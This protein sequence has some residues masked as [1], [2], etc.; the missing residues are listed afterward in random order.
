MYGDVT[1]QENITIGEGESLTLDDGASLDAG[2]HNV[3]VD[4]GT[5][6]ENLENSLGDSVKYTPT[7]TT[8]SLPDG[9][10]G[11]EYSTTLAAEGTAPIT[12][13]V[14]NGT[15]P[16]GLSL[17]ESTGEISGT[18]AAAGKYTFEIEAKNDYGS[19]TGELT[20]EIKAAPIYSVSVTPDK[21]NLPSVTEGYNSQ[22]PETITIENAG[23]QTIL[24]EPLDFYPGVT[25]TLNKR[26]LDPGEKAIVT[27]KLK[28]NLSADTPSTLKAFI[29]YTSKD[30]T[31][32]RGEAEF[33]VSYAVKHD[34]T[35]V[36]AK[37]PTHLEDGNIECWYCEYCNLYYT[38]AA[39]NTELNLDKV[40]I[41][42]LKEHTADG[43]GWHSDETNHWNTCACGEK[44]N[45][46]AHTFEWV[47]DKEATAAEAG[48][49]HEECTVCGYAKAAVEIPATGASESS[50]TGDDSSIALWTALLLLAAVVATGTVIYGRKRRE[51]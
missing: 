46:A 42:K 10:V 8:E 6:D 19:E 50:E 15:L 25:V 11:T 26:E 35:H 20:I 34:M 4:G 17:N 36:E 48:L 49:K 32:F 16:E 37:E 41:P 39:G 51:Q 2:N 40:I 24:L 43:T 21:I 3:I 33:E 31:T 38:G 5:L 22:E 13:S 44:L 29:T 28:D 27:I 45:E 23:D 18:P 7:I 12:W 14:R 9:T 30:S 47:T 1:L